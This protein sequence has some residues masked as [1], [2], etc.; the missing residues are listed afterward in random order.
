MIEILS[1]YELEKMREAGK[2]VAKI[3]VKLGEEIKPG[4]S[5]QDLDDI[6]MNL[7]KEAGGSAP[8]VGYGNPPFP[9]AICTSINDEV[10]HGIP[11]KKRIIKDGDIVTCD[12][13][14]EL[15]G[16]NADAARTYLVGNVPEATRLLV[17][18]TKQSFFE[19]FKQVKIGNRIGDVSH[20]V[21]EYAES[22]GYGVVRVLTGHGIG[23]SMHQEPD[24]PNYGKPGRGPRIQKGMAFCLEPMINMGT[25]YVEMED[26]EWTIVT[27][28]GAPSAHYEN[29][30]IITENGPEMTTI[31]EVLNG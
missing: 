26:D 22:F 4:M 19:G 1:D 9:A 27:A 18:R 6:A 8:C 12:V 23:K 29:T 17:E 3:L 2:L 7:I 24:V 14:A 15:N 20:A 11:S 28:D 16:Y 30:I 25:H 31:E 13:V 5:T 10:V 21:Q